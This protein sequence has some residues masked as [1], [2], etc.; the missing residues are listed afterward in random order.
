MS[1]DLIGRFKVMYAMQMRNTNLIVKSMPLY[2]KYDLEVY[3]QGKPET[4]VYIEVKDRDN[5]EDRYPTAYLNIE[6]YEE[7]KDIANKWFFCNVYTDGKIDLWKPYE[8]PQSG[9]TEETR[10]I[11]KTTVKKSKK[12]PQKRYCLNFNDK[13]KQLINKLQITLIDDQDGSGRE[14]ISHRTTP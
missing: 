9:I 7:A 12:I 8:M 14:D 5:T 6:K 3:E 10:L 2:S 1:A 13:C 4:K 11:A